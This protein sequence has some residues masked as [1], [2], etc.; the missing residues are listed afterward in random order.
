MTCRGGVRGAFPA[1][2]RSTGRA[3][4]ND[5]AVAVVGSDGVIDRIVAGAVFDDQAARPI[6]VKAAAVGDQVVSFDP[7]IGVDG[8]DA[9]K[10]KPATIVQDKAIGRNSYPISK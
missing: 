3:N 9:C 5:W 10:I 2:R 4:I 8:V 6:D 7:I 1:H